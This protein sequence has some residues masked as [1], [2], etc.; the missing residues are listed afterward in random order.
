MMIYLIF[1]LVLIV[2]I[3]VIAYFFCM[4][5][6]KLETGDLDDMNSPANKPLKEHHE[7]IAK[8]VDFINSKE[9]EWV[10]TISFDGLKLMARYFNN[11]FD[12]TI[13]LFHGYRSSASRDFSCAVKMYLDF[14]FN[15]LLVD[16]RSHGKSEGKL[17]TFGVKES[18][19]VISWL[20]YVNNRFSPQKIIISGMSMGAT[21]VLLSL[22]YK[23][24]QNVVGVIAD[25]GFTSPVDIIKLVAKKS[26]KI[27]AGF[28]IP[29][30]NFCCLLFGGFSL[31][32][33]NTLNSVKKSNLPILLIHGMADNFVPPEMSKSVLS[34]REKNTEIFLVENAGH[35]LGFLVDTA[36]AMEK[37]EAF[38]KK[39]IQ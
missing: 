14:G 12:K 1:A 35:G 11:N 23:M 3:C 29:V 24:P 31:Y 36:G 17:I 30:L 26:I 22:D 10:E 6:V 9:C 25:S 5:F 39:C 16:Q 28:F 32:K 19:D 13:F 7:V 8:G 38:I 37:L 34:E 21:T 27:N 18:R 33:A 2:V 20:D 15:I 4:A